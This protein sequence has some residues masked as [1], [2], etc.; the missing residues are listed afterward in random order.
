LYNFLCALGLTPTGEQHAGLP[1][2]AD[3]ATAI[4]KYDELFA[5]DKKFEEQDI[6][7]WFL[8][9]DPKEEGLI[10]ITKLQGE[11][12]PN[13][14]VQPLTAAEL[15]QLKND[16]GG[17]LNGGKWSY[18]NY[19]QFMYNNQNMKTGTSTYG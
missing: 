2:G 15:D 7:S 4:A 13:S 1:D 5:V 12:D 6:K 8:T 11:C 3:Q 17:D 14:K 19:L 18:N 10:D 9:W 16:L